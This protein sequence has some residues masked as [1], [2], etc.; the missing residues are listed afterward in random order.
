MKLAIADLIDWKSILR[1]AA[2]CLLALPILV[3]F[4]WLPGPQVVRAGVASLL[5]ASTV[6]LLAYRFGVGDVG[7]VAGFVWSRV[8]RRAR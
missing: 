1:I 3:V 6:L 5:Y 4:A 8:G 2:S 7:R